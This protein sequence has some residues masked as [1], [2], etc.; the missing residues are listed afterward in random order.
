ML[1][2]T[3]E[4][5]RKKVYQQ[6][7]DAGVAEGVEAHQQTLFQFI[8]WR[9]QTS[10]EEQQQVAHQIAQIHSLQQLTELSEVFLQVAT[11]NEFTKRVATYLP[12]HNSH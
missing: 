7:K 6:G 4:Q 1:V 3:L 10:V 11:L 2:A 12:P 9:F 8:H 5:E